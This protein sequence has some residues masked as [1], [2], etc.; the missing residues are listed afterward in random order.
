MTLVIDPPIVINKDHNLNKNTIEQ[1]ISFLY[2]IVRDKSLL[3]TRQ[4]HQTNYAN[5]FSD[6]FI[7]NEKKQ[8]KKYLYDRLLSMEK[9]QNNENFSYNGVVE[10]DINKKEPIEN[11]LKI[12]FAV[13]NKSYPCIKG[14]R[15]VKE[16]GKLRYTE[17]VVLQNKNGDSH[18]IQDIKNLIKFFILMPMHKYKYK[19]IAQQKITA[20]KNSKN[21]IHLVRFIIPKQYVKTMQ[22]YHS[23]ERLLLQNLNLINNDRMKGYCSLF[24]MKGT[25]EDIESNYRPYLTKF[26]KIFYHTWMPN[27]CKQEYI[28]KKLDTKLNYS[29]KK[30]NKI[31]QNNFIGNIVKADK[32]SPILDLSNDDNSIFIAKL[33]GS[34]EIYTP[35]YHT[36]LYFQVAKKPLTKIIA[37]DR[38]IY[39]G[40]SDGYLYKIVKSNKK[41]KIFKKIKIFN[42]KIT[43]I[44]PLSFN[45]LIVSSLAGK[46][47]TINTESL[48]QKKILDNKKIVKKIGIYNKNII[49]AFK[50]IKFLNKNYSAIHTYTCKMPVVA[51]EIYNDNLFSICGNNIINWNL[52]KP[53]NLLNNKKI[54]LKQG[55]AI[56]DM[57][58]YK[59][60]YIFSS[61]YGNI[62]IYD[63]NFNQIKVFNIH[64]EKINKLLYYKDKIYMATHSGTIYVLDIKL[65]YLLLQ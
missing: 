9:H 21:Q 31:I 12:G 48:K 45:T 46:I 10:M 38:F 7:K 25:G 34:M 64:D 43:D 39:I 37:M 56:S 41:F 53:Y 15:S 4:S 55:D 23:Q 2:S 5:R 62:L 51:L 49:Y 44:K 8:N 54:P 20:I 58:L 60:L 28:Y 18:N 24:N 29:E 65:G 30:L 32:L 17:F 3:N 26:N 63:K 22:I 27:S 13:I 52:R 42:S 16:K 40:S 57:L 36:M 11:T 47:K 59:N 35:K 50:N 14:Y 6:I 61:K 1:S 33:N 19:L